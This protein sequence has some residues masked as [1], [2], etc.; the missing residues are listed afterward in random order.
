MRARVRLGPCV[1]A[2]LLS[3][4]AISGCGGDDQEE[5][6]ADTR[7]TSEDLDRHMA[8]FLAQQGLSPEYLRPPSY[9]GCV[10]AARQ[11][12]GEPQESTA[13][14]RAQCARQLE[15]MKT[16]AVTDLV[17]T[18]WYRQE[19]KRRK[20]DISKAVAANFKEATLAPGF[21]QTL[22]QSGQTKADMR[23]FLESL[24]QRAA[25]LRDTDVTRDELLDHY[26]KN[27]EAFGTPRRRTIHYVLGPTK[28]K[29]EEAK[30]A[31]E[32][33]E[34]PDGL[35][36][37]IYTTAY[38][39]GRAARDIELA[40]RAFAAKEDAIGGPLK[41]SVGWYAF[42]V[43]SRREVPEQQAPQVKDAL[44]TLKLDRELQE[45]YQEHTTC[46]KPYARQIAECRGDGDQE[47]N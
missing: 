7:I 22:E 24:E 8:T 32:D 13:S 1:V 11:A 26:R 23:R 43:K 39:F 29:A 41:T 17:R 20:L 38:G 35:K 3:V 16:A 30:R 15:S 12:G 4:I 42:E 14:L 2:I 40:G 47:S 31:L 36:K 33:G 18:R 46:P 5:P 34:E 10:K 27:I 44:R 19:L 6:V 28:A 25:L 21:E 9:P 45:R 37:V